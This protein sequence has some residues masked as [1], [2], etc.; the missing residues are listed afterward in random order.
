MQFNI[1]PLQNMK[2]IYWD[3]T[4]G[5][6]TTKQQEASLGLFLLFSL[7]P[8]HQLFLPVKNEFFLHTVTNSCSQGD[9]WLLGLLSLIFMVFTLQH[10]AP[11]G[12]CKLSWGL[13]NEKIKYYSERK[14]IF[15]FA[16]LNYLTAAQ[17]SLVTC[18]VISYPQ[19][20]ISLST[21]SSF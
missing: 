21:W 6:S 9:V 15:F 7:S 18:G 16:I 10:E 5:I 1:V 17:I 20:N 13:T 3:R 12:N 2:L 11:S 14:I 19:F 4:C 8:H